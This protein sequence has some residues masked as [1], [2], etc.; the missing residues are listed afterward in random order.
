LS[1]VVF[2]A[3]VEA[4][5]ERRVNRQAEFLLRLQLVDLIDDFEEHRQRSGFEAARAWL[6]NHAELLVSRA[7]AQI[8]LGIELL[9]LEAETLLSFGSLVG[10][11]LPLDRRLRD[12]SREESVRAANLGGKYA[13]L[14]ATAP[15]TGGFLRVAVDT[16]QFADNV[17][18]VRRIFL[19]SIPVVLLV[20]AGVGWLLSRGA[21]RPIARINAAAR[22]ISHAR[23]DASIPTSGSGDELDELAGTLNEMM[24]R[25]RDGVHRIERFNANAA[26]ELR[27][28]LNRI[29]QQLEALR[30]ES[31]MPASAAERFEKIAAYTAEM[32]RE[33][34]AMLQLASVEQGIPSDRLHSV[35]VGAL[36]QTV[37]DF[38]RPE[39]EAGGLS[40]TTSI[41]E[42]CRVLGDET[43]LR[44]LASNLVSNAI[45]YVPRGGAV[46]VGLKRSGA[47]LEITV[48]DSGPG[49]APE[50]VEKIF[51]RFERGPGTSEGGFGLGL[52]I[53][54]EIARA[55][56]GEVSVS[57]RPG[58]GCHFRVS[59]PAH[60]QPGTGL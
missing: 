19:L 40:F 27:S 43:W 29:N 36:L 12:G 23:T 48:D 47:A 60:D 32:T 5:V 9:S 16:E 38:F 6:T 51:E 45:K 54:R 56:G 58:Q 17:R 30:Q 53:A 1:L 33:I 8:G 42:N 2:A 28:P 34:E 59:L 31:E 24:R 15:V 18:D 44:Q 52:S 4:Q 50:Q 20:S 14:A 57:S 46:H 7:D 3:L 25:I 35:E 41:P 26:H 10:R 55:H 37:A 49:I 13:Y 22:Q 21:L 11:H 39:A